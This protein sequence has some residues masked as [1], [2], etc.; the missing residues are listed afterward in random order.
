MNK[1]YFQGIC[2]GTCY[3]LVM[4][5]Q[6][7]WYSLVLIPHMSYMI[8]SISHTILS[9]KIRLQY[10][11]KCICYPSKLNFICTRDIFTDLSRMSSIL[12][13]M[14]NIFCL[15][16]DSIHQGKSSNSYFHIGHLDILCGICL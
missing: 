5:C 11:A 12:P 4:R 6:S 1:I 2:I 10:I 8:L 14:A 13:S 7:N 16:N 9:S 3:F 15:P